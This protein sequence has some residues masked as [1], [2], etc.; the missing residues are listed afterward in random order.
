MVGDGAEALVEQLD[1]TTL[2]VHSERR[3]PVTDTLHPSLYSP[4]LTAT[5]GGPLWVAAGEDIWALNPSTGV[6]ETEFDAG[7][8]IGSMST[9]PDGTLLYT[10]GLTSDDGGS[11]V[12]EY[13]ARTGRQLNR[14]DQQAAVGAGTVA[15]TNGGV[16]VSYRTGMAGPALELSSKDLS[17]IAPPNNPNG[18]FDTFDQIMGVGS[19]VSEGVLWLTSS[20][21]ITCANPSTSVVRA[22]E[23]ATVSDP[24]AI[25]G[26][27]YALPPSGGVVVITPPKTC[28]GM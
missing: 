17:K 28:F 15:A 2:A 6:I 1:P 26:L 16:W 20:N 4:V 7:N 5:V 21:E 3:L 22:S 25:G 9:A 23:S 14:S 12:T 10:I 18:P 8:Q 24:V 11:I 19:G 13:D 27:L